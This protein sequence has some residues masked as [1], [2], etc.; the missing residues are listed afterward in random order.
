[1]AAFAVDERPALDEAHV[2]GL[3]VCVVGVQGEAGIDGEVQG[4]FVLKADADGV[5]AAG[6]EDLDIIHNFA[7]ELFHLVKGAVAVAADRGFSAPGF[8]KAKERR[9]AFRL[10][11][12]CAFP[13]L[14]RAAMLAR[15]M[16]LLLD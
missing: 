2:T 7:L 12:F 10:L 1:M 11:A 4:S 16:L 15:R 14:L 5:V 6:S 13:G 3:P 9:N 8:F